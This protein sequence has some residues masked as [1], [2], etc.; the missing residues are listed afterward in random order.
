MASSDRTVELLA[1]NELKRNLLFLEQL[2]QFTE[3]RAL[4][5]LFQQDFV[6]FLTGLDGFYH[7]V[8]PEQVLHSVFFHNSYCSSFASV[9]IQCI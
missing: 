3:L 4:K 8:H 5:S 6:K 1:R 9:V 7:G 2:H